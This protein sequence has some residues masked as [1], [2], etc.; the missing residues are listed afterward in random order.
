MVQMILL[1]WRVD[2]EFSAHA[3]AAVLALSVIRKDVSATDGKLILKSK[4]PRQNRRP[5]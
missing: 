5:R 3:D 2:A 4:K 1:L